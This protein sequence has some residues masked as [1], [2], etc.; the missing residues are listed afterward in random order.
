MLDDKTTFV[1]FQRH[2]SHISLSGNINTRKGATSLQ[3]HNKD[4]ISSQIYP[5]IS[6]NPFS[7]RCLFLFYFSCSR[8]S[9]CLC[10][11]IFSCIW[12]TT[13]NTSGNFYRSSMLMMYPF[14]MSRADFSL[15]LMLKLVL[16]SLQLA[17]VPFVI[18]V[19]V[20]HSKFSSHLLLKYVFLGIFCTVPTKLSGWTSIT[21]CYKDLIDSLTK[22]LTLYNLRFIV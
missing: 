9:F 15:L 17:V 5:K 11:F 21:F 20:F 18:I 16:R 10:Y 14:G 19:Q 8:T 13:H 3:F 4:I 7:Y 1:F 2:F 6:S 12:E 22:W